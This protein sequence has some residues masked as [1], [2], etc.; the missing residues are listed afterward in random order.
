MRTLKYFIIGSGIIIVRDIFMILV[1][2]IVW[3][4]LTST[5]HPVS[6]ISGIIICTFAFYY[7]KKNLPLKKIENVNMLKLVSL[8]FFI[9]LNLYVGAFY[10]IKVIIVGE[11][12]DIITAETKLKNET[13]IALLGDIITI[14]PGSIM[15]DI[16]G[17][18]I[19]AL[20]LRKKT[21]PDLDKMDNPG[22]VLM[23]YIE[24]RLI[25]AQK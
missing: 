19:T 17:D 23:G 2:Y 5:F 16:S 25:P 18:K 9:I 24:K 7:S 22:E 6:L 21:E 3:I 20:W 11:R 8:P 1:M 10:L 4:I 15:I 14:I 13:L 12:L